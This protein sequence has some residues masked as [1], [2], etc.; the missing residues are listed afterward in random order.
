MVSRPSSTWTRKSLKQWTVSKES[1][2]RCRFW[3]EH[4]T[5]SASHCTRRLPTLK[6]NTYPWRDNLIT[7]QIQFGNGLVPYQARNASTIKRK[8]NVLPVFGRYFFLTIP[9]GYN[10][11]IRNRSRLAEVDSQFVGRIGNTHAMAS[12]AIQIRLRYCLPSACDAQDGKRVVDILHWRL[13]DD[14][15]GQIPFRMQR[16]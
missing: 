6:L 7:R 16:R 1:G 11:Y 14:S 9:R 15:F 3:R 2:S 12:A 5:K 4:T 13:A 8:E 10:I